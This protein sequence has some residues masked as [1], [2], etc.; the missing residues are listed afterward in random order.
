MI[1]RSNRNASEMNAIQKNT[2]SV[3]MESASERNQE[4]KELAKKGNI[5][6]LA[7]RSK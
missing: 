2:A 4:W 5:L 6:S 1:M 3:P 7:K